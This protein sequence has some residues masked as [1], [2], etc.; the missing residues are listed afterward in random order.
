L[1]PAV[2][3][4]TQDIS[5]LTGMPQRILKEMYDPVLF[6]EKINSNI[7]ILI[8]TLDDVVPNMWV[9]EFAKAQEA[10]IKFLKDDHSF[11]LNIDKLPNIINNILNKKH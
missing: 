3:P 8:G 5:K 4:P 7:F 11:T 9:I 6:T 10:T 2:I 1:N